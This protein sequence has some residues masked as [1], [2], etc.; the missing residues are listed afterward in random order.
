MARSA[1]STC[2]LTVE[3]LTA[4]RPQRA[5]VGA[6]MRYLA[7]CSPEERAEAMARVDA[8][9]AEIQ[10]APIAFTGPGI[11]K[12][13]TSLYLKKNMVPVAFVI[14][15]DHRA[16]RGTLRASTDGSVRRS[17][18]FSAE[19]LIIE[20]QDENLVLAGI[21]RRTRTWINEK[22]KSARLG[23]AARSDLEGEATDERRATWKRLCEI[24]DATEQIIDKARKIPTRRSTLTGLN[25]W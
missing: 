20:E 4:D 5:S 1:R 11:P 14:L 8:A 3:Q 6:A 24:A 19:R 23:Y 2:R 10:A 7:R 9:F 12:A 13:R 22:N 16:D 17:F 18:W 21:P 25:P 15:E